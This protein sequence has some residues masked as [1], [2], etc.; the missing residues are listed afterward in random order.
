MKEYD[1]AVKKWLLA[2]RSYA[3]LPGRRVPIVGITS[4][5]LQD[6][7]GATVSSLNSVAVSSLWS[8]EDSE[9]NVALQVQ[10]K[11]DAIIEEKNTA[12]FY[13]ANPTLDQTAAPAANK[14]K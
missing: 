6:V 2:H 13:A 5:Y 14:E 4:D 3:K 7:Q 1:K 9:D 11:I 10:A 8:S 12:T